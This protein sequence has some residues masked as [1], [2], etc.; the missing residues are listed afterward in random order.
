[1]MRLQG[2]CWLT[3]VVTRSPAGSFRCW[4]KQIGQLN[5]RYEKPKATAGRPRQLVAVACDQAQNPGPSNLRL[6]NALSLRSA[7]GPHADSHRATSWRCWRQKALP[8]AW[9]A[10]GSG[11]P[12]G[13]T[14]AL[15]H[16]LYMRQDT[17][18]RQQVRKLMWQSRELMQKTK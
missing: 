1:M 7:S 11:A 3:G 16:G 14:H 9:R 12:R 6:I 18:E 5:C 2:G 17:A 10:P 15:K 8:Y 4:L 13:N